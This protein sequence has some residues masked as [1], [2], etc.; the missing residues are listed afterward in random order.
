MYDDFFSLYKKQ[1]Q[2]RDLKFRAKTEKIRKKRGLNVMADLEVK[3]RFL[4]M[5]PDWTQEQ[6]DTYIP[7]SGAIFE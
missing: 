4:L 6:R 1:Y 2:D 3:E 5:D 7:Y